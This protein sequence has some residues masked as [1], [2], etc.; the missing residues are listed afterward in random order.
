MYARKKKK[1]FSKVKT[2]TTTFKARWLLVQ[3]LP[4]NIVPAHFQAAFGS[5]LTHHR[6]LFRYIDFWRWYFNNS[7]INSIM[8]SNHLLH[9]YHSF[10]AFSLFGC[11]FL[12]LSNSLFTMTYHSWARVGASLSKMMD[13]FY[14][15]SLFC[16]WYMSDMFHMFHT[17]KKIK[18][19]KK[20]TTK[21]KKNHFL[22]MQQRENERTRTEP[23]P[24]RTGHFH[25]H[26]RPK[27]HLLTSYVVQMTYFIFH[28]ASERRATRRKEWEG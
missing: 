19:E 16:L 10:A 14:T 17:F 3:F 25:K 6:D 12:K 11:P 2:N 24:A 22:Q 27:P 28:I 5:K 9:R 4:S 8:L 13:L 23:T 26:L 1:L 21:K 7:G 15:R 18:E 20:P